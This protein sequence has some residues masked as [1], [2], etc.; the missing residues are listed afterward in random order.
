MGQNPC[1]GYVLT[2]TDVGLHT[3]T[4]TLSNA[5]INTAVMNKIL[6]I[7]NGHRKSLWTL[8]LKTLA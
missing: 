1:P 6:I 7:S 5:Q 2:N 4:H 3:H 8:S